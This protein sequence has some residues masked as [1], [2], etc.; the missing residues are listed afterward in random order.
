MKLKTDICCI[1]ESKVESVDCKMCRAL[2]GNRP[3]E[4]AY[5]G[6]EGSSGGIITLWNP[7]VFQRISDWSR[8]G[9]VVV[10]GR[11]VEDGGNCTIINVYAP[12]TAILR[13]EIWDYIQSVVGQYN[14]DRVCIM[15]DFNSI[16]D[17]GERVGRA[18][19][20][21]IADINRFN[22]FIQGSDLTEIQLVGRSFTWY[23][24][25]GSCKSKLDRLLVNTNWLSKWPCVS[26]KGGWRSLSD[27]VPI[28]IEG[29]ERDWGPRPFKFF[30]QWIQHQE[31]RTLIEK[32]WAESSVS[33]WAGF[34]IKEKLKIL[35][36]EL[37]GWSKVVFGELERKIEEKKTEIERLDI[38]DDALGLEPEEEEQRRNLMND[39]MKETNWRE[40][41]LFQKAR[42]KWIKEGDANSKFFHNWV[43]KRHK[44]NELSGLWQ[45]NVWLESVGDV[46]SAIQRYFK[47]QFESAPE[48]P[49]SFED[50]LFH[51]KL[52]A[53]GNMFLVAAFS[54]EEIKQAI[55]SC[56]SNGSPGPDGF[57][58]GFFKAH[59][60]LLKP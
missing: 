60:G 26:L 52:E 6:S 34:V 51:K 32:V 8:T 31:Y 53:E 35:K 43:K 20:W 38:M 46:K 7:E 58:F 59:W 47:A 33:G 19:T 5:L 10:N 23:R 57:S 16:R 27:H 12:N 24:P 14:E 11:W 39:L 13:W 21:D 28:F 56:D 2:W 42:V 50:S 3:C 25:N 4:W 1:Q 37:K 9:M 55:W 18:A 44:R 29:A 41:Q 15:G 22:N 30:N 40:K 17:T 49:L 36:S 45:G 54:R 48:T